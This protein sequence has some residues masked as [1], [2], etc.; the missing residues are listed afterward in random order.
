MNHGA[1][2]V[3][4]EEADADRSVTGEGRRRNPAAAALV[5]A[6]RERDSAVLGPAGARR[7]GPCP[8]SAGPPARRAAELGP[9]RGDVLE[10][11]SA[12]PGASDRTLGCLGCFVTNRHDQVTARLSV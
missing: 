2:V 4:P 8:A 9:A 7:Q 5:L 3:S 6:Y 11:P 12:V 10:P 1:D